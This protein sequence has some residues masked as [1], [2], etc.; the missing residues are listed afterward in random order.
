MIILIFE[1]VMNS[2]LYYHYINLG[3]KATVAIINNWS[4]N[5]LNDPNILFEFVTQDNKKAIIILDC[6]KWA[7]I[8]TGY[9]PH[10]GPSVKFNF[11]FNFKINKDK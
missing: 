11:N 5:L 3:K 9:P 7:T 8:F 10:R 6:T 1:D 4:D 2:T